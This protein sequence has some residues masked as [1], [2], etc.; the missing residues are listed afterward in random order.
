MSY[1]IASALVIAFFPL[2]CLDGPTNLADLGELE[3]GLR[4]TGGFAGV[5][6]TILVDG[7]QREVV[8]ES[9][10]SGCDFETGA[11]LH[12]LTDDQL[13]YLEYLFQEADV[14]DLDGTDFGVQCCDQFHYDLTYSDVSGESRVKGSSEALPPDLREAIGAV[15]G[16]V[17]EV[18]PVVIAPDADPATWSQGSAVF[19]AWEIRGD[20]LD[21]EVSH[22]VGCGPHHLDL[23]VYGGWMESFPVQTRAFFS[24]DGNGQACTTEYLTR[25]VS[26]DLKPLKWAYQ[27]A[28]GVSEPGATTLVI[29]LDPRP[30]PSSLPYHALEYVF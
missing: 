11:V 19:L 8:G 29:L 3:I 12:G 4:V 7:A 17:Y 5:D 24:A 2:G 21:V 9:C 13:S 20:Y 15:A 26:F 6:Y 28:Y 23:V 22:P 1:R 10:I 18:V 16:F 14:H 25:N 27:E 30:S